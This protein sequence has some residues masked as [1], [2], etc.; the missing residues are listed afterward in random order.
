MLANDRA[1]SPK[2]VV[3][4]D[5]VDPEVLKADAAGNESNT[6]TGIPE[7]NIV[8]VPPIRQTVQPITISL[9]TDVDDGE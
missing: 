9:D 5:G 1:P 6:T 2:F 8:R 4:L 3:T 7:R